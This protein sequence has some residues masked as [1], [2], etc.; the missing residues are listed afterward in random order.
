MS[1][2]SPLTCQE[3]VELVTAYLEHALPAADRGRVE[4]H[5]ARCEGCGRYLDQVRTTIRVAG[6]SGEVG[7]GEMPQEQLDQLVVAFRD[8]KAG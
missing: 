1:D 5:L 7:V 8:W 3:V 4:E 2:L 6:V